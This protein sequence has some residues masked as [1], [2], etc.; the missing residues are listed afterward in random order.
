M[1][2]IKLSSFYWSGRAWVHRQSEALRFETEP[3][4]SHQTFP[5]PRIVELEAMQPT[6]T[7]LS[8]S[9]DG[10]EREH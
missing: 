2:I 3:D 7:D 5:A 9:G 10:H 6:L 4:L 1:W 8:T